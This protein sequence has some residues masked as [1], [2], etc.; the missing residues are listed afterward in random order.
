M[1]D[2]KAKF[3]FSAIP[4]RAI[5]DQR[6][7]ALHFRL[8]AAVA[9]HDRMSQGSQGQGCWASLRTLADDCGCHYNSLSPVLHDLGGWGYLHLDR[10][11]DDR[12]RHVLRVIYTGEDAVVVKRGEMLR[13]QPNNVVRPQTGI[14]EVV[15]PPNEQA[16]D[17]IEGSPH[18]ILRN[19]FRRSDNTFSETGSGGRSANAVLAIVQRRLKAREPIPTAELQGMTESVTRILEEADGGSQTYG[20]ANAVLSDL[21]QRAAA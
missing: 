16:S 12:R 20:W 10:H 14:P 15:N 3:S 8:L 21:E 4:A 17:F 2:A 18:N 6:L 1:S 13:Q 5:G 7:T 19:T 9:L 11:P